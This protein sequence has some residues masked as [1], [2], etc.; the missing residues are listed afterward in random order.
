MEFAEA[1]DDG[2]LPATIAAVVSAA[3]AQGEQL[4]ALAPAGRRLR[5][6][7][8]VVLAGPPNAGKSSLFNALLGEDRVLV[9]AEAG[10]TR[11]V[12]TARVVRG[13]LLY[14]LHDTAGLR[15]VGGRVEMLGM[16][17]TEAAVANADVVIAVQAADDPAP[18]MVSA[19]AGSALVS[20]LAKADL[21]HAGAPGVGATPLDAVVTASLTGAGIA[22][23]WQRIEHEAGAANLHA[24]AARGVLLNERHQERLR[25]CLAH[26]NE[27]ASLL[28]VSAPPT[29]V[30]AAYLRFALLELDEI[31]GRVFTE[32]LLADVFARFCV[33]K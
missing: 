13:G 2:P 4:A 14:V 26:L 21:L 11:D 22:D 12:V 18:V 9:D 1:E 3:C 33:G 19:P 6:G 25:G 10:T 5:E 23:L 16:R 31:S 30:V 8:H 24:A 17:R 15:E 32:Q 7:V 28:A 27:L 29:E 20:V